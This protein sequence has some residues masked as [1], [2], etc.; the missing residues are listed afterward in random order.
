MS[1]FIISKKPVLAN[2]KRELFAERL[3]FIVNQIIYQKIFAPPLDKGTQFVYNVVA[4]HNLCTFAKYLREVDIMKISEIRNLT[5]M[6]QRQF[7]EYFGIPVGTL[8]NW[9]QGISNPPEY[10]FQMIVT[11]IRRDKMI[12]LETMKFMKMLDELAQFTK[13]GIAPFR[14]ATEETYHTQIFYDERRLEGERGYRVVADACIFD[15]PDC[16]HHDIISYYDSDSLEY[17]IRV[18]FDE[19]IDDDD[20]DQFVYVEVEL[21]ISEDIIVIENGRWYFA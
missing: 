1:V 17:R 13:K 6:S 20:D 5:Q 7:A 12:N 9:E 4:V 16:Y 21:A 14:E 18:K 11:S 8:R 19:D 3:R 10:V 2:A 15:D